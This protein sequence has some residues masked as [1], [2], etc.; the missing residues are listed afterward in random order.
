[1][2]S[3]DNSLYAINP[4]GSQKWAFKTGGGVHSSPTLEETL[5]LLKTE[6]FELAFG[7]INF[8]FINRN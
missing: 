6:G 5:A 4:D 7:K 2:G 1:M 3:L 8:T